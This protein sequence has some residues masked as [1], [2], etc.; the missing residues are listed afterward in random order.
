VIGGYVE[1]SEDE[2]PEFTREWIQAAAK[3]LRPGG[4]LAVVTGP[5][6][7][8]TVQCAAE[9]AGLT[10][11]TKI[12][13]HKEFPLATVRRPARCPLG[14]PR[15]GSRTAEPSRPRVPGAGTTCPAPAAATH[16]PW[17]GG[18]TTGAPTGPDWPA[19]TTPLPLKMVR[20]IVWCFSNPLDHV[21]VP[22]AQ[23]VGARRPVIRSAPVPRH[24][25][26]LPAYVKR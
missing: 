7:S 24:A 14:H 16:I 22:A 23:H 26:R 4:Q 19:M 12:A 5:Q 21:A 10:F 2:Y 9:Q 25:G 18:R 1:V 13:A 11:V 3:A 20:R 6:R 17:T 8:G 15:D